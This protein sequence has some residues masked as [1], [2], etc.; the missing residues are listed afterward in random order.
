MAKNAGRAYGKTASKIAR[1]PKTAYKGGGK[2][3]KGAGKKGKC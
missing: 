2:M 1:T 3:S